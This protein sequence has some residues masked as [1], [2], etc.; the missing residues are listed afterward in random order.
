MTINKREFIFGA[1]AAAASAAATVAPASGQAFPSKPIRIIAPFAAGGN[2]D[3]TAQRLV[4]EAIS[5]Q[6]LPAR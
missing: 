2:V 3:V 1:F 6:R 4:G 5:R